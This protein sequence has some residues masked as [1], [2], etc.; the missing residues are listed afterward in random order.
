MFNF[1]STE[2]CGKVFYLML[3]LSVLCQRQ[4]YNNALHCRWRGVKR[5]RILY[6]IHDIFFACVDKT[7][8]FRRN[9]SRS[10]PDTPLHICI[11]L[12]SRSFSGFFL[13]R[14]VLFFKK[15]NV[16]AKKRYYFSLN[17]IIH[18]LWQVITKW[19]RCSSCHNNHNNIINIIVHI[20]MFYYCT[21]SIAYCAA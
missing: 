13:R 15:M 11:I 7:C 21:C 16:M 6:G 9:M 5:N 2:L 20:D 17:R 1:Q 12:F 10:T 14:F 3:L 8:I 19:Q 4:D 18:C